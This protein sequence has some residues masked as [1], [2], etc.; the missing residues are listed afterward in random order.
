MVESRSDL[1]EQVC[2]PCRGD[3][4]PIPPERIAKMLKLVP[5]WTLKKGPDQIERTYQFKDF[6]RAMEFVNKVTDIAESQDHHPDIFIHWNEVTLTFWTHAINGLFGN[7]F[8]VAAK[9][10]E[11]TESDPD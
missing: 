7:D 9:I 5:G 2:I 11:I 4:P 6:K 8:I 10:D 1:A 3:T